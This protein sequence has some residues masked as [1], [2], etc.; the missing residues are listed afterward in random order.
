MKLVCISGSPRANGN[1]VAVIKEFS[2]LAEAKNYEVT[3]HYLNKLN[4]KGCQ[5]CMACKVGGKE[6]CVIND[7]LKTVLEDVENTDVIL[8]ASPVYLGDVTSQAKGFLDRLYSFLTPDFYT[9]E[10]KTRLKD[11][12]KFIFALVQG[13]PVEEQFNDIYP[14]YSLFLKW[15]FGEAHLIRECGCISKQTIEKNS[16][17]LD[18]IKKVALEVL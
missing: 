16:K 1:S 5:G 3:T 15:F 11:G 7:D 13:S 9:A 2:R 14:R 18:N 4:Y 12:K 10:K 17:R 8:L 6:R